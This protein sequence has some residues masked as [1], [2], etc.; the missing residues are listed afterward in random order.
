MNKV[1]KI[2]GDK[3][4]IGFPDGDL[5]EYPLSVFEFHVQV[6]NNVEIFENSEQIHI[7]LFEEDTTQT[8][9]DSFAFAAI[10]LGLFALIV[11]IP[12]LDIFA[13]TL[14]VILAIAAK[15]TGVKKLATVAFGLSVVGLIVA[16]QFT[17]IR[18]G[19]VSL[20]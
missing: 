5:K 11:T 17:L 6:G 4:L 19:V 3:V 1:L 15:G 16:V 9:K 18:F 2:T 13:G 10:G 7:K 14:G 12:I 20:P 8:P